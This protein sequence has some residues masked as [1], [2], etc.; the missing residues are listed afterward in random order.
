MYF[1]VYYKMYTR[2]SHNLNPKVGEKGTCCM[3]DMPW[4]LCIDPDSWAK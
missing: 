1:D 4:G 2:S 3:Q